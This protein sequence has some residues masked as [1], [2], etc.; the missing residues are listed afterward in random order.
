M[1]KSQLRDFTN[2]IIFSKYLDILKND[3]TEKISNTILKLSNIQTL[4]KLDEEYI[5]NLLEKDKNKRNQRYNLANSKIKE[6]KGLKQINQLEN[7][8][9][10]EKLNK[11]CL[12]LETLNIK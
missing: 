7:N 11:I 10:I 5:I 4:T 1:R 3:K 8:L 6:L 9:N 12:R 2:W